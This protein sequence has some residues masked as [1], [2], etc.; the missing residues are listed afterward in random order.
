MPNRKG[1]SLKH[2]RR[3]VKRIMNKKLNGQT[4]QQA[5]NYHHKPTKWS[6]FPEVS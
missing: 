5:K 2:C 3:M 6:V 4:K 1:V